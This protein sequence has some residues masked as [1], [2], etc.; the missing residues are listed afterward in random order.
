MKER[1]SVRLKAS[2]PFLIASLIPLIFLPACKHSGAPAPN[3]LAPAPSETAAASTEVLK[4]MLPAIAESGIN[5]ELPAWMSYG[6]GFTER[7]QSWRYREISAREQVLDF[8]TPLHS[9]AVAQDG[10]GDVAIYVGRNGISHFFRIDRN[11]QALRGIAVL[12]EDENPIIISSAEAQ[13]EVNA[14]L[15]FWDANAERAVH[16]QVCNGDLSGVNQVNVKTKLESCRWIIESGKETPRDLANAYTSRGMAYERDD[17]VPKELE[18]LNRAIKTDPACTRAWAQLC[19]VQN[20]ITGETQLAIQSCSKAIEL[21]PLSPE[22]WT[23]RGDIYLKNKQY[24]LA[25]ADYDHAIELNPT[26]MWPLDNRGEAYLHKNEIDRAIENFNAVI[27]VNPDHAIGFLDRG[28]A[29]MRKNDLDTALADFQTGIKVDPHCASCLV[30][31][32]LVKRAKGDQAGG[33]ADIAKAMEMNPKAADYFRKDGIP[34][35]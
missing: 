16:W 26:W 14:E 18:D 6:L 8:S 31:Q 7:G 9:I 27:R 33:D 10:V 19:G 17:N 22:G 28:I 4:K 11:G 5:A 25:I 15:R 24:D 2:K 21:D 35:P 34:V 29:E 12:D 1:H 30:G 3:A 32:G 20:W 13:A 23:F